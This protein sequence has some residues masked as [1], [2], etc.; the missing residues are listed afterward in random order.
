MLVS[1]FIIIHVSLNNDFMLRHQ[2]SKVAS[3]VASYPSFTDVL[4]V[5][6]NNGDIYVLYLLLYINAFPEDYP[7]LQDTQYKDYR[8][9][10]SLMKSYALMHNHVNNSHWA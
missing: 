1:D 10:Y 3:S 4:S 9:I 8:L 5:I 6:I 7:T 2:F